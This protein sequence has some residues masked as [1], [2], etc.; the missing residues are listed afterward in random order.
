MNHHDRKRHLRHGRVFAPSWYDVP[1]VLKREIGAFCV[2]SGRQRKNCPT[3][4]QAQIVACIG[5]R[6]FSV[7]PRSRRA[8]PCGQLA[9]YT[10]A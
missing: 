2:V 3:P 4:V 1:P 8:L 5:F 7:A 10:R 9:T 6:E